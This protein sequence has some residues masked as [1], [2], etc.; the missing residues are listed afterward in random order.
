VLADGVI[1]QSHYAPKPY[2]ADPLCFLEILDWGRKRELKSREEDAART[3]KRSMGLWRGSARTGSVSPALPRRLLPLHL[4]DHT[5]ATRGAI[6]QLGERLD[7]TQ[8]VGGSSPPSSIHKVPAK[9]QVFMVVPAGPIGVILSTG[10]FTGPIAG[11]SVVSWPL[12]DGRDGR[13]SAPRPCRSQAWNWT[14]AR[15]TWRT[16]SCMAA[17]SS[18]LE[19]SSGQSSLGSVGPHLGVGRKRSL[20]SP[21]FS[22]FCGT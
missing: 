12:E 20:R 14:R 7:R 6:A 19:V 8:E 5:L 9:S 21:T 4:P 22:G 15:S 18:F 2:L 16:A 10:P 17:R 3:S 11:G 1:E 13:R